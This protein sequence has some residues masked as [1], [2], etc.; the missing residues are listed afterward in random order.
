[1]GGFDSHVLP[2][3]FL[4][5]DFV[6]ERIEYIDYST[7]EQVVM[8]AEDSGE[9]NKETNNTTTDDASPKLKM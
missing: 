4:S 5:S 6:V 8:V 3:L 2:P 9:E 7:G 1:M